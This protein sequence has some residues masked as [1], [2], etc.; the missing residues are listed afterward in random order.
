MRTITA[1]PTIAHTAVKRNPGQYSG[2]MSDLKF[3]AARINGGESDG[4]KPPKKIRYVLD[5][6]AL[7]A[8]KAALENAEVVSYDIESAS[9]HP[10]FLEKDPSSKI[11]SIAFTL[12][13]K[14]RKVSVWAR[15][16]EHT[17]EL[18]SLMR[19]S[20]AVFCLKK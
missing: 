15:S 19:I 7:R 13:N 18:Q 2:F 12:V 1:I 20:Y 5:K 3:F 11:V 4:V 16:E 6:P 10:G 14:D 17:S 8:L 9:E